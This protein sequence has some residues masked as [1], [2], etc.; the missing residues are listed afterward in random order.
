MI[1]YLKIATNAV[2][3][4]S[5]L[6]YLFITIRQQSNASMK[7]KGVAISISKF[8]LAARLPSVFRLK[9]ITNTH[10]DMSMT[11]EEIFILINFPLTRTMKT[12]K[13][14]ITIEMLS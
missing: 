4:R 5:L 12:R 11:F 13:Q 3:V 9:R 6:F 2:V 1:V 14:L 10:K 8:V 7:V